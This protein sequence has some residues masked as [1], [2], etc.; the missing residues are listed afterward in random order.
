MNIP[1][2]IHSGTATKA[3]DLKAGQRV[4]IGIDT[5]ILKSVITKDGVTYLKTA[6]RNGR[7]GYHQYPATRTLYTY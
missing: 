5:K 1:S 2:S 6:L 7:T 3:Q 4:A